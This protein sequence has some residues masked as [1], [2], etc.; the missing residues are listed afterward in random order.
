[1]KL[2]VYT[3]PNGLKLRCGCPFARRGKRCVLKGRIR[4]NNL[5]T[6]EVHVQCP[7]RT[8]RVSVHLEYD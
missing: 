4:C 6:R 5:V 8:G 7:L 1:M 2:V 3:A